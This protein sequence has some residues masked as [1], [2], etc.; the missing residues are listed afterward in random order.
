[1]IKLRQSR[2]KTFYSFVFDHYPNLPPP[3]KFILL[4]KQNQWNCNFPL[5]PFLVLVLLLKIV[6]AILT[7]FKCILWFE[8]GVAFSPLRWHFSLSS[9]SRNKKTTCM[10]ILFPSQ[11]KLHHTTH[12]DIQWCIWTML[13]ARG[14]WLCSSAQSFLATVCLNNF[15]L[16]GRKKR[17]RER[18]RDRKFFLM[19]HSFNTHK[20]WAVAVPKPG[21]LAT[22]I[23]LKLP[24]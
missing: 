24:L 18:V 12:R 1:M 22:S 10:Q 8:E 23:E 2:I 6:W 15:Y 21:V 9:C 19:V 14:T 16:N 13:I 17:A 11:Q 7:L 4:C 3:V 20:S 5:I